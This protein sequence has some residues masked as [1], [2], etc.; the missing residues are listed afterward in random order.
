MRDNEE[1]DGVD[2]SDEAWSPLVEQWRSQIRLVGGNPVENLEIGSE[3]FGVRL[4]SGQSVWR[5]VNL[6]ERAEIRD[7]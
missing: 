5:D 6:D 7:G 2:E 3:E 4:S 1:S